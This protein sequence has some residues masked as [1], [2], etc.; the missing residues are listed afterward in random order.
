MCPGTEPELCTSGDMENV[1]RVNLLKLVKFNLTSMCCCI[2]HRDCLLHSQNHCTRYTC[3]AGVKA[4][5]AAPWLLSIWLKAFSIHLRLGVYKCNA[6]PWGHGT[7][8]YVL[9]VKLGKD[10][11]R[12]QD[13]FKKHQFTVRYCVWV[14][15]SLCNSVDKSTC[16]SI[17]ALIMFI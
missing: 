11:L 5:R 2:G 10:Y 15:K 16:C 1:Q 9:D 8:W 4:Q 7:A 3:T 12:Y 13:P 6:S 17:T 14:M